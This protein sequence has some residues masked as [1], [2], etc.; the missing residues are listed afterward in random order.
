MHTKRKNYVWPLIIQVIFDKL[1]VA[2]WPFSSGS[3][4]RCSCEYPQQYHLHQRYI[5]PLVWCNKQCFRHATRSFVFCFALRVR[6]P[7]QQLSLNIKDSIRG[8]T[9]LLGCTYM[10]A[11]D[12]WAQK[13]G[14]RRF[15]FQL[16][17]TGSK[18]QP[19]RMVAWNGP[20]KA[21]GCRLR[22]CMAQWPPR[23]TIASNSVLDVG[24]IKAI[25]TANLHFAFS[26]IASVVIIRSI[27]VTFQ[28]R[29]SI[30]KT[31]V[32]IALLPFVKLVQWLLVKAKLSFCSP[33]S[34]IP[35]TEF[36]PG[37]AAAVIDSKAKAIFQLCL[38]IN[39]ISASYS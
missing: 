9:I 21:R 7:S 19:V 32:N 16:S 39:L 13:E 38:P 25:N 4:N 30:T 37:K 22:G 27:R 14:S 15:K 11:N 2:E 6:F 26:P 20:I 23:Y 29:T 8:R 18:L 31:W 12:V 3:C 34:E 28:M 24:A 33:C 35:K 1:E 10:S 36:G 17:V 5:H